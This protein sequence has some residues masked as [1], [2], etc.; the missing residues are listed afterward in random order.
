MA[1]FGVGRGLPGDY[2]QDYDDEEMPYTPAWQEKF[3]GIDRQTVVQF[4]REWASTTD[5]TRG[6]CTI[7]IGAGINHWYH[8]NLFYRAGIVGLMLTGCVG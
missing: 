2:P 1:Q 8:N 5:R 3:T 6:Q 7:I 4:T